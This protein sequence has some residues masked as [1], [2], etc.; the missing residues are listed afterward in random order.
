[1]ATHYVEHNNRGIVRESDRPLDEFGDMFIRDTI[2][3]DIIR[4]IRSK[5]EPTLDSKVYRQKPFGFRTNFTDFDEHGDIKIYNK[6]SKRGY[7]YI[8][9]NRIQVNTNI[10]DKWKLVTSRS[11]SVPE[12]DNGQVLRL[13]QT[14]IVEPQAIVT[15]SYI[16]VNVCDTKEEAERCYSYLKTKLFRFLCQPTIVSP[17]VSKRTF[18]FVPLL[19]T[20]IQWDDDMLYKRYNLS[21]EEIDY[22]ENN[23]KEAN[24]D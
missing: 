18:I 14:F 8:F 17:D 4:K 11:T 3:C 2:A 19:S 5:N 15:E 22:I 1:M 16:V 24:G 9:R 7:D 13:S 20:D 21:P 23:I 6:K 10:I 12:E